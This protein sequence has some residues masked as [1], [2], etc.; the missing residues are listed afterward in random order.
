MEKF[1]QKTIILIQEN[2]FGNAVCKM[3]AILLKPKCLEWIE[4]EDKLRI[5]ARNMMDTTTCKELLTESQKQFRIR[6][7]KCRLNPKSM[8]TDHVLLLF[9]FG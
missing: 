2:A 5:T 8:H 7:L 4:S 6:Q 3:W 1:S 9:W